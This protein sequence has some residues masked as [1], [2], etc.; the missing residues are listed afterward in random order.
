MDH[1]WWRISPASWVRLRRKALEKLCVVKIRSEHTRNSETIRR[2]RVSRDLKPSIGLITLFN[3]LKE[4]PSRFVI[5][6]AYRVAR[7]EF[8]FGINGNENILI[9]KFSAPAFATRN[10]HMIGGY[11]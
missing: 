11:I 5:S 6:L 2:K 3:V 7:N 8:C 4:A 9:A 10:R 1:F